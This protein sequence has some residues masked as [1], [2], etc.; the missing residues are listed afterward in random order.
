MKKHLYLLFIVPL[1][2]GCYVLSQAGPYLSQRGNSTKIEKML[3]DPET[4]PETRAFLERVLDIKKYADSL[5]LAEDRNYT[6]Y[7]ELDKDYLA[8]V[9][10]ACAPWSFD[11]YMWTYPFLGKMPYKGF[12]NEK[13][14][15]NEVKKLREKNLDIYVRKVEAFSSLGYFRDP[16]YSFMRSYSAYDLAE[17]LLHEQ[18]HATVYYKNQSQFNEELATFVGETAARDYI[19]DRF[20]SDSTEFKAIDINRKNREHY[21]N[22]M[23]GLRNKLQELYEKDLGPEMTGPE[24]ERIISDFQ[25]DV[26]RNYDSYFSDDNYRGLATFKLN[27]AYISLF[28]TYTGDLELFQKVYEHCGQSIPALMERM[29]ALKGEKDLKAVMRTWLD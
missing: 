12:I 23:I 1:F 15:K 16:L 24:K 21:R 17:L 6:T 20:G 26:D 14:V 28:H 5:G 25:Q 13:G 19:A 27:N 3:D 4:D 11:T 29:K 7:K 2:S 22:L 10:S 9:I 18:T 8:I